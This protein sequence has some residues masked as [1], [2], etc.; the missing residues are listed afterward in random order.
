[1]VVLIA[2]VAACALFLVHTP[3][4]GVE[5]PTANDDSLGTVTASG[6]AYEAVPSN[7]AV[8]L[9]WVEEGSIV[10]I[11]DTIVP[12]PG[13]K[14]VA[15]F[16]DS[17]VKEVSYSWKCP[18]FG[19]DG[20]ALESVSLAETLTLELSKTAYYASLAD[21]T[22]RMA[23]SSV[24]MPTSRLTDDAAIEAAA[25][26]LEPLLEGKTN[27]QKAETVL[28]FVQDAIAYVSDQ[29]QYGTVEWWATPMET[30]YSGQ[31]D[32]EDTAALFVALACRLGLDAGFVA[33]DDEVMGHMSAAVRLEDGEAAATTFERSDGTVWAYC[34]TAV[35]GKR[36]HV[37]YL[38][39]AFDISEGM[40]TRVTFDDGSYE[41]SAT[42]RI[43]ASHT[44]ASVCHYGDGFGPRSDSG[45][46][47]VSGTLQ[48]PYRA[49]AGVR[50]ASAGIPAGRFT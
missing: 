17:D 40:W 14:L 38:S 31:G 47:E 41:G 1:M 37:G 6:A 44:G 15:V 18:I 42:V 48:T 7:G 16:S 24:P 12:S 43:G 28:A 30:L 5:A 35:D 21:R 50:G 8:F 39:P 9:G 45:A 27:I 2:A 3:D 13:Q 49:P 36:L 29:D 33:F 19:A 22:G 46:S 4:A 20:Q 26:H 10:S 11:A 23:T 32:C 34:E 25:E